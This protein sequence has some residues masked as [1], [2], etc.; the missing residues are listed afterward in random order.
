L[1]LRLLFSKKREGEASYSLE[2]VRGLA[3]APSL[4]WRKDANA[5]GAWGD[6][7]S[8]I[9]AGIILGSLAVKEGTY[10]CLFA[11]G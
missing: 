10:A 6:R 1:I 7:I 4:S 5:A 2:K 8:S 3:K 11:R 9:S